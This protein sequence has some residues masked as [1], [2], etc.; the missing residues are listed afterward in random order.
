MNRNLILGFGQHLLPLPPML[1]QTVIAKNAQQTKAALG[2]MSAEHHLV[3]NFV[4][5]EL[6]R[7][8]EPLSPQYISQQLNLPLPRV[9][10]ILDELEKEKTFLFRNEQGSVTWA[11]PVTIETTPHRLVFSTGEQIYAA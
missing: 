2:F 8:A 9:S 10:Q 3:R 6:P 5:Q 11:Y 7:V 1:W 4:V